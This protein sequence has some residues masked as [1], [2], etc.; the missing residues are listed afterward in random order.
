VNRR[1]V[2]T[3]LEGLSASQFH[4]PQKSSRP[5]RNLLFLPNQGGSIPD[6]DGGS[7]PDAN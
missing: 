2:M 5:S 4:P 3:H 7:I 6:A 1:A